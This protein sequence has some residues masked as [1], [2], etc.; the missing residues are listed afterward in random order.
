[1]KMAGID[2]TEDI[3]GMAVMTEALDPTETE[4]QEILTGIEARKDLEVM[5]EMEDGSRTERRTSHK[6]RAHD[7]ESAL[8]NGDCNMKK[9]ILGTI[10]MAF[11]MVAP[12]SATAMGGRVDIGVNIPLPPPIHFAAPPD[13]VVI[14]ETYVYFV[15]DVEEEIFFYGGWWWRPWNGRWYRSQSYNSGWAYYESV[16]SFYRDVPSGWRNN[17][18]QRRWG[19]RPWNYQRIPQ[20]QVYQNWNNWERDRHWEKQNNWGVQDLRPQQRT[21]QPAPVAPQQQIQPRLQETPQVPVRQQQSIPKAR[22][23]EQQG[24]QPQT[25]EEEEQQQPGPPQGKRG[26]GHKEKQGRQDD[27]R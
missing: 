15:P 7:T 25:Y 21:Q 8:M 3:T 19:G 18:R 23:L 16:P 26:K 22:Q 6:R 12:I 10:F 14:P 9:M 17:Y 27:G 5:T 11:I 4:A 13:M 1:M 20:Q 24:S 2:E